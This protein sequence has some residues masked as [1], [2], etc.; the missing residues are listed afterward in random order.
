MNVKNA[1]TIITLLFSI[2]VNAQELPCETQIKHLIGTELIEGIQ[3]TVVPDGTVD[4]LSVYCN[5]TLPYLIGSD[6]VVANQSGA[7]T[8]GFIPPV[9]QINLNFSGIDNNGVDVEYVVIKRNFQDYLITEIGTPNG[10]DNLAIIDQGNI[11]GA[12]D[13]TT[14]GWLGT[15]IEG[16][17]YSITVYD[18][19]VSGRPNGS[20]F[21]IFMCKEFTSG[22]DEIQDEDIIVYPNP[23]SNYFNFTTGQ[24]ESNVVIYNLVGRKVIDQEINDQKRIYVN[25]LPKGAY[26]A[27]IIIKDKSFIRK[28]IITD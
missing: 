10:C 26:F 28:L 4:S 11:T 12:L 22:L 15:T 9:S 25:H 19:I 2:F 6:Y 18:S 23:T 14:S 17:I 7:Y 3:V 27:E 5:E 1:L 13:G 20:V 8:F 16:P 24:N 21:S